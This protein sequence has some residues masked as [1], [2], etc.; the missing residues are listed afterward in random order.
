MKKI[1]NVFKS[2]PLSFIITDAENSAS[3]NY[4]V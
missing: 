4:I 1:S 2:E 3:H